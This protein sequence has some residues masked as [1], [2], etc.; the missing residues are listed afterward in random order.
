ME[1]QWVDTEKTMIRRE[2]EGGTQFIPVTQ[3]NEVYREEVLPFLKSGGEI[4]QS[5]S[6]IPIA[7]TID[8]AGFREAVSLLPEYERI[9]NAIAIKNPTRQTSVVQV[10]ST[11]QDEAT[12][13]RAIKFWNLLVVPDAAITKN[14]ASAIQDVANRFELLM[15]VA[16]NGL[17]S[18]PN[19][20]GQDGTGT[21]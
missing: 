19:P 4:T 2:V 18:L 14:E 17:L 10:W 11:V 9:L 15:F 13:L 12:L 21:D 5:A 3:D 20:Q 8:Y 7:P 6:S 1:F 16:D